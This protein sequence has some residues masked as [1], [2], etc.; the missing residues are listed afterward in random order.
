MT[1]TVLTDTD[2][3]ELLDNLTLNDVEKLQDSLR[4]S[5]HEYSTGN[6]EDDCCSTN[7]PDRTVMQQNGKTTLFMPSTSSLGIGMKGTP[8]SRSH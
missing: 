5:L 1:L 8:Q 6:Q 7:Q 4:K 2:V 3:K